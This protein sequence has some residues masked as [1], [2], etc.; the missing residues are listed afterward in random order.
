MTNV[1]RLAAAE[2]TS[3]R[4]PNREVSVGGSRCFAEWLAGPDIGVGLSPFQANRVFLGGRGEHGG[5][6]ADE[7]PFDRP[8]VLHAKGDSPHMACRTQTWQPENCLVPGETHKGPDRLCVTAL[9]RTTGDLDSHDMAPGRPG[10]ALFSSAGSSC[11]TTV[12]SGSFSGL[13][14][15]G[16][17]AADNRASRCGRRVIDMNTGQVVHDRRIEGVVEVPFDVVV[18]PGARRSDAAG[19]QD[20]AVGRRLNAPGSN[21]LVLAKPG[22]Q[23]TAGQAMREPGLPGALQTTRSLP[24]DAAA[25]PAALAALTTCQRVFHLT[26][27][28]LRLCESMASS[29][30][31]RCPATQPGRGELPGLSASQGEAVVGLSVAELFTADNGQARAELISLHVLPAQAQGDMQARLVGRPMAR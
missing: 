15:G 23:T 26:S 8:K 22:V 7:P 21:G 17:I 1:S 12:W 16:R 13:A 18:Q 2:P 4:T 24:Q 30:L 28:N 10:P 19:L 9:A 14:L 20:D 11:L 29:S 31:Q 6:A 27:G 3:V 5:L 25:S